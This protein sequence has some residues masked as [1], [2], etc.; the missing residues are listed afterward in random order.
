MTP[1]IWVPRG[2]RIPK[3]PPVCMVLRYTY[4]EGVGSVTVPKNWSTQWLASKV[5]TQI[6]EAEVGAL[7][8]SGGEDLAKPCLS[9]PL[10]L[11]MMG[12]DASF[13][14]EELASSDFMLTSAISWFI[15]SQT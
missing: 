10:P 2:L 1:V 12:E 11:F 5:R 8:V 14:V 6:D 9:L 7:R 15:L 3:P 4:S 13:W